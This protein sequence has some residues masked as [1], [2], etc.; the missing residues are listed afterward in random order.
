MPSDKPP[1]N[2]PPI[3]PNTASPPLL[4][5]DQ[6]ADKPLADR[7][8]DLYKAI[9]KARSIIE[10][11]K[12]GSSC[13]LKIWIF[14]CLLIIIGSFCLGYEFYTNPYPTICSLPS[15]ASQPFSNSW[16][17]IYPITIRIIIVTAV[18]SL[19]SFCLKMLRSSLYIFEKYKHKFVVIESLPSLVKS[20]PDSLKESFVFKKLLQIIVDF[21]N[22]G[23]LNKE[24]DMKIVWQ[25]ILKQLKTTNEMLGKKAKE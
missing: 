20:Y 8:D 5:P 24:D 9:E 15:N 6:S 23:L 4:P 16:Y 2:N 10:K 18:F 19:I 21:G 13:T 11:A 7:I 25:D 12:N 17:L 1:I 3:P 14:I 22:T